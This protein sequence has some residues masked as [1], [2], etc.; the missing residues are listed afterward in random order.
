[1]QENRGCGENKPPCDGVV[2]CKEVLLRPGDSAIVDEP[3]HAGMRR[4]V[5]KA[6]VPEGWTLFPV[7]AV[8]WTPEI[9]QAARRAARDAVLMPSSN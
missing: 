2:S 5:I 6:V 4:T 9:I 3:G 1:M 8:P 7:F